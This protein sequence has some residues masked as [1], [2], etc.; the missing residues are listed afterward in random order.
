MILFITRSVGAVLMAVVANTASAE[1]LDRVLAVVAGEVITLSDVRGETE[2][3]L[4]DTAGA[5]DPIGTALE[6]L[7]ERTLVLAE[8]DRYAPPEPA[9]A[10]IQARLDAI[11][12]RIQADRL[13]A[14][15]ARSGLSAPRLREIVRDD[16]RIEG[17]LEQRFSAAAQPSDDEV[18]AYYRA[19]AQEFAAAPSIDAAHLRVREH[20]AKYAANH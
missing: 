8:V 13:I 5:T 3:G 18:A 15:L 12:Q 14:I 2:L 1:I 9:D 6:R 10:A 16:L 17:Y 19:H 4:I 20:L 7:I 11:A